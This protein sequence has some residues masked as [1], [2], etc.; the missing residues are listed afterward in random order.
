[1]RQ[2]ARAYRRG[3]P[4]VRPSPAR[5]P[6]AL[7][8]RPSPAPFPCAFPLHLF[9][10]PF[11]CFLVSP[12]PAGSGPEPA[13]E[14]LQHEWGQISVTGGVGVNAAAVG[15]RGEGDVRAKV[16][17]D[18]AAVSG[19]RVGVDLVPAAC[20]T[21]REEVGGDVALGIAGAEPAG[22]AAGGSGIVEARRVQA[23]PDEERVVAQAVVRAVVGLDAFGDAVAD[24]QDPGSRRRGRAGSA[25]LS[26]ASGAASADLSASVFPHRGQPVRPG[27]AEADRPTSHSHPRIHIGRQGD[28][29]DEAATF[30][31]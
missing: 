17:Q 11:P 16:N 23:L 27:P 9:P 4:C 18:G 28:M 29:G 21:G 22:I 5:V 1:M 3:E 20:A 26:G 25:R 31:I 13:Q 10:A 14:G 8:L 12:A 19:G 2:G 6:C 15:G 24:D 7:P 30:L